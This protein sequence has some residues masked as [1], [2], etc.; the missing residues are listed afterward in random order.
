MS[1]DGGINSLIAEQALLSLVQ[2][3]GGIASSWSSSIEGWSHD[4]DISVCNWT[5]VTCDNSNKTSGSSGGRHDGIGIGSIIV[6]EI[7]RH[8]ETTN[9]C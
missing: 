8:L 1:D 5:G 9:L 2:G 3:S 4:A 6:T 7:H